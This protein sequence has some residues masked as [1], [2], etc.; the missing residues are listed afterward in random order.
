MSAIAVRTVLLFRAAAWGRV[1]PG[2]GGV[3]RAGVRSGPRRSGIRRGAARGRGKSDRSSWW[4]SG[5]PRPSRPSQAT[6]SG[7]GAGLHRRASARAAAAQRR[8]VWDGYFVSRCKDAR[9]R[10]SALASAEN[11]RPAAVAGP[12]RFRSDRPL[13]RPR[14]RL[15]RPDQ[16][17]LTADPSAVAP[18]HADR[19][20]A[21]RGAGIQN[22]VTSSGASCNRT[23]AASASVPSC[24]RSSLKSFN[25]GAR[26]SASIPLGLRPRRQRL[27]RTPTGR[28]VVA[29]DVE[30]AQPGRKQQAGE[31]RGRQGSGQRQGGHDLAQRQHRL[32]A[33]A[34]R[35]HVAGRPE[36]NRVAEQ[37]THR[38]PRHRNRRLATAGRIEPGA[39]HTRDSAVSVGDRGDQR[40]PG[41][42]GVLRVVSL[43][44][45]P[46]ARDES[47]ARSYPGSRRCRAPADRCWRACRRSAWTS[48]TAGARLRLFRPGRRPARFGAATLR[49][50]QTGRKQATGATAPMVSAR[51]TAW[52]RPV[53]RRCHPGCAQPR[54]DRA[55][56]HADPLPRRSN[57]QRRDH[58]MP[59]H[60]AAHKGCA[61]ACCGHRRPASSGL[62]GGRSDR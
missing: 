21:S 29:D 8:T 61:P 22:R 54:S 4:V 30:P 1:R 13:R 51:E 18:D 49:A 26:V 37:V 12:L 27:V 48:G 34:G 17:T 41:V 24:R 55:D 15:S 25:A 20:R 11:S 3:R 5:W 62:P 35:H 52:P 19:S 53:R 43:P 59:T 47:A 46:A 39:L 33:L 44:P 32:D 6:K 50:W 31:I 7:G 57:G 28:V 36:A 10:Y 40:R 16:A 23:E 56:P 38:P 9:A 60:S 58:R 45:V 14:V 2:T 42:A